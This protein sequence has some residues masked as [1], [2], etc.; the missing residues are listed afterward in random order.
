PSPSGSSHGFK[1]ALM[2]LMRYGA[3]KMSNKKP[4]IPTN[5]KPKKCHN[6]APAAYIMTMLVNTSTTP[7]PRSGC[8]IINP[9]ATITRINEGKKPFIKEVIYFLYS[10]KYVVRKM[11]NP[12]LINSAG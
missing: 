9:K 2:R 8:N 6:L 1:K 7:V 10:H 3:D 5:P 11:I 4:I 12:N